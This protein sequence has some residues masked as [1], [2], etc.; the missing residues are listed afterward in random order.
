MH[1]G[2]IKEFKENWAQLTQDT[3]VLQMVQGFQLPFIGQPV[4]TSQLQLSLAQQL[5]LGINR[6]T[7]NDRETGYKYGAVTPEGLCEG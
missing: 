7:G 5:G 6:D 2:R 3:W 4:Q 1:A